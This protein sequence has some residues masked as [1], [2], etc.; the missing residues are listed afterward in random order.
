MNVTTELNLYK[1]KWVYDISCGQRKVEH[2]GVF[3]DKTKIPIFRTIKKPLEDNRLEKF[4]RN[5]HD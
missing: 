5:N 3:N 4:I 2:I 1:L